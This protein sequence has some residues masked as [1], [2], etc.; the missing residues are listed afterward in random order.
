MTI[1][2]N[3]LTTVATVYI[4]RLLEQYYNKTQKDND[5]EQ[6]IDYLYRKVHQLELSLTY[7]HQSVEDIEEKVNAKNNQVIESTIALNSKLDE[8][9]NYNY[10][11]M[12]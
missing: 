1:V 5:L 8:F 6:K 11:F 3:S 7:L 10:D 4:V 2:I 9:I 12:E